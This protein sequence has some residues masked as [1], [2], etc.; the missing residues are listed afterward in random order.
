AEGILLYFN[1]GYLEAILI[2]DY[3]FQYFWNDYY[4]YTAK[5]KAIRDFEKLKM[6]LFK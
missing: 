6:R 3:L 5:E 2:V 4:N 1:G